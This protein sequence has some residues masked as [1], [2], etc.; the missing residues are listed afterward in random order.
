MI[1][2]AGVFHLYRTAREAA[3]ALGRAGF[4]DSQVNLLSPASSEQEIHSIPTSDTEQPGVGAAI[5]GMLG[6]AVGVA[7][8]LELGMAAAVLIPGSLFILARRSEL[9][10]LFVG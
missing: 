5:G 7:G 4:R 2:V 8:G 10:A 1:T 6:G 3:D 9:S